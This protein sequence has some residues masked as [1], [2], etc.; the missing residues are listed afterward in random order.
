MS[1]RVEGCN[2]E[3]GETANRG[4]RTQCREADTKRAEDWD[5]VHSLRSGFVQ[6]YDDSGSPYYHDLRTHR[7]MWASE[8]DWVET[9]DKSGRVVQRNVITGD[10][11]AVGFAGSTQ[12]EIGSERCWENNSSQCAEA[13]RSAAARLR[14][15][16]HIF[17]KLALENAR[18]LSLYT[19]VSRDELDP[20]VKES[21][22]ILGQRLSRAELVARAH[23]GGSRKGAYY[24]ANYGASSHSDNSCGDSDA[25]TGSDDDDVDDSMT[26]LLFRAMREAFTS[27]ARRATTARINPAPAIDVAG[28]VAPEIGRPKD[29]VSDDLEC[30]DS[31]SSSMPSGRVITG[32]S[33]YDTS[34]DSVT[35]AFQKMSL[36]ERTAWLRKILCHF[37]A[38][39]A[40]RTGDL[41][42]F[43]TVAGLPLLSTLLSAAVVT[44]TNATQPIVGSIEARAEVASLD[45]NHMRFSREKWTTT[46][47]TC[48]MDLIDACAS[49]FHEILGEDCKAAP[50]TASTQPSGAVAPLALHVVVSLRCNHDVHSTRVDDVERGSRVILMPDTPECMLF[51]ATTTLPQLIS[52][53]TNLRERLAAV[54]VPSMTLSTL[55]TTLDLCDVPLTTPQH[56][57]EASP[58]SKT[59]AT[60]GLV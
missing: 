42:R 18:Q 48:D 60:H 40:A 23:S 51:A 54:V 53:E 1:A 27:L 7:S 15:H 39:V 4:M 16:H 35:S 14:S 46:L 11:I 12:H 44:T 29:S 41:A 17:G 5:A 25:S 6:Y 50:P 26:W 3:N 22:D 31:D 45:P 59:S 52:L 43:L 28:A 21:V 9:A 56:A 33:V 49:N 32:V 13:P 34:P 19:H 55:D 47:Q 8:N 2:V 37:G 24:T 30:I 57:V 58:E 38:E 20:D 36:Q 10:C